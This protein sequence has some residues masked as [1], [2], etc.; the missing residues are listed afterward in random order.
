MRVRRH[1]AIAYCTNNILMFEFRLAQIQ[2]DGSFCVIWQV[3]RF[4]DTCRHR[5]G[6]Q[7]SSPVGFL[8]DSFAIIFTYN[9]SFDTI[10]NK[11]QNAGFGN[12]NFLSYFLNVV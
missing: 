7:S 2:I 11:R 10:S 3:F 8:R 9:N 1:E 5:L 4:A 12:V 6:L